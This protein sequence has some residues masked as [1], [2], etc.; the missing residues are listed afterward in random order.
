MLSEWK[1]K[2]RRDWPQIRISDVQIDHAD[3]THIQVGDKLAVRARVDLGPVEPGEVMR[4]GVLR[5]EP[6]ERHRA[7]DDHWS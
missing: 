4:A 3:R 1:N 7:A 6:R 2:M 5:R